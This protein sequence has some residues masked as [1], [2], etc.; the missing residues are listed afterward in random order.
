[1]PTDAELERI[2]HEDI[3]VARPLLRRAARTASAPATRALTL[4]LLATRDAGTATARICARALRLDGDALVRR[5]G[6]ECLGRV[7]GR[8]ASAHTA[9]LVAALADPDLDVVTM[10]GWAA[11]AVGEAGA[12]RS[13][14]ALAS[15]PD[16]RV[17]ALFR[18]YAHKLRDRYGL[19]AAPSAT[20]PGRP[21]PSM[22]ASSDAS[23]DPNAPTA[24]PPGVA[25]TLPARSVDVGVSTAWLGLYGT[26]TGWLHGPLLVAA[27]GGPAGGEVGTLVGLGLGTA[28]GAA[29]SAYGFATADT[30][31]RAHTIVQ[32]GT[33]GALAGYGAGQLVGFPPISGVASANLATVGT[34]AGV[35]LG[36]AFL[37]G[38]EP[39]MGALAAGVAASVATGTAGGVLAASYGYPFHQTLGVTL[40]TGGIAGVAATTLLSRADLGLFPVAGATLGAMV[41]GGAGTLLMANVEPGL[42][43]GRPQTE[44]TGWVVLSSIALGAALGGAGGT[45]LPATVDPFRAGTLRLL[46]PTVGVLPGAG[47][48]AEPVTMAMVGGAF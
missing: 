10:A 36:M 1:M 32:L 39:T 12:I 27:H 5:A 46:P 22:L 3:A 35:G 15:H 26:M 45:W 43:T 21:P 24:A 17:A 44:S 30:L 6:A 9:A 2:A 28:A 19:S 34:L 38:Q 14:A 20:A 42:G 18:G 4:R 37:A 7:G 29:L 8:F 23:T 41:A 11:A 13:V 33:L 31:P 40:A 47:V 25:L 48:R 16:D